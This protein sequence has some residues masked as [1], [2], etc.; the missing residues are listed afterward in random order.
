[1]PNNRQPRRLREVDLGDLTSEAPAQRANRNRSL[2]RFQRAELIGAL[3]LTLFAFEVLPA[4]QNQPKNAP[5]HIPD[6]PLRAEDVQAAANNIGAAL[7]AQWRLHPDDPRFRIGTTNDGSLWVSFV[8]HQNMPGTQMRADND[9]L[10][11][12]IYINPA[13]AHEVGLPEVIGVYMNYDST[14]NDA[15]GHSVT[16]DKDPAG[17]PGILYT[18]GTGRA[19]VHDVLSYYAQND[20]RLSAGPAMTYLQLQSVVT[21]AELAIQEGV[22]QP[23]VAPPLPPALD[24]HT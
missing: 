2:K 19:G 14:G 10:D 9:R 22:E 16:L 11:V 3:L 6:R 12:V 17:Q 24:I 7:Y 13:S 23:I 5:P 15:D 18:V 4:E 20:P 8:A 1:M 21:H